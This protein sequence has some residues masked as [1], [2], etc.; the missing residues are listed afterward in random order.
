MAQSYVG[1]H[2]DIEKD[3]NSYTEVCDDYVSRSAFLGVSGERLH[4]TMDEPAAAAD[5]RPGDVLV[6]VILQRRGSHDTDEV[7]DAGRAAIT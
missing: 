7:E 1:K 2:S 4:N 6:G 3:R 5:M